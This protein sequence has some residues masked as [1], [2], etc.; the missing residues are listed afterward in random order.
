M[1]NFINNKKFLYTIIAIFIIIVNV[2]LFLLPFCVVA[3]QEND[4][5]DGTFAQP[6]KALI[7]PQTGNIFVLNRLENNIIVLDGEKYKVIANIPVKAKNLVDM[8]FNQAGDLYVFS[9]G[10]DR[11]V[12]FSLISQIKNFD[13]NSIQEI[14]QREQFIEFGCQAGGHGDIDLALNKLYIICYDRE[15]LS[16]IN[17]NNKEITK[18][19]LGRELSTIKVDSITHDVYIIKLNEKT[20]SVMSGITNELTKSIPIEAKFP[21]YFMIGKNKQTFLINRDEGVTYF[22]KDYRVVGNIKSQQDGPSRMAL[23]D[24]TQKLYVSNWL[25]ASVSVMDVKNYKLVKKISLPKGSFPA[26]ITID[27][28][29]N[30]IFVSIVG[31]NRIVVIDGDNNEIIANFKT[32]IN[33]V[34]S[35]ISLAG[36]ELFFPN[37]G[38][39]SVTIVSWTGKNNFFEKTMPDNK[40]I[41]PSDDNFQSPMKLVVNDKN[42]DVYILN[43][44][45][46]NFIIMDGKTY[47]VKKKIIVGQ[48]PNDII[49]VPE[50]DK[51]FVSIGDE[52]KIFIYDVINGSQKTI[53]V[54]D[55]PTSLLF[56]KNNNKLYII[57]YN[58]A[59]LSVVD[60]NNEFSVSNISIGNGNGRIFVVDDNGEKLF[61]SNTNNEI[62]MIDTFT[63]QETNRIKLEYVIKGIFYDKNYNDIYVWED[64]G[65]NISII[66]VEFKKIKN[67]ICLEGEIVYSATL[68]KEESKVI[69]S[70]NKGM[71]F[72]DLNSLNIDSANTI[73]ERPLK[74]IVDAEKNK[75]FGLNNTG[76]NSISVLS[77]LNQQQTESLLIFDTFPYLRESFNSD[78]IINGALNKSIN[79]LFVSLSSQNSIIVVDT[80]NDRFEAIISNNG[81]EKVSYP[82]DKNIKNILLLGFGIIALGVVSIFVI[83]KTRNKKL[84]TVS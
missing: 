81:I 39:N 6:I 71:K 48:N 51:V 3:A 84:I 80:K 43:N 2:F 7:S 67:N 45:G 13:E 61:I 19:N 65:C 70:T 47:L 60:I 17:G 79:K 26:Y 28:K 1:E 11:A 52:D 36:N 30:L 64:H 35:T 24:V 56:N 41:V 58:A 29:N 10:S 32:G 16:V 69:I 23:N 21:F 18:I 8:I 59:D 42:N 82:A 9:E 37:S 14:L 72:T 68:L 38:S 77:L 74:I 12:L 46:G 27:I 33:P 25:S 4:I 15:N 54:G 5:N 34:E 66:D 20:I 50:V 83:N 76:T 75:L 31:E 44:F 62:V 40:G 49:F 57:N 63:G 22:I 55:K 78:E 53:T 73:N